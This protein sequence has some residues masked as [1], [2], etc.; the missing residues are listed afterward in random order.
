[1]DKKKQRFSAVVWWIK[2]VTAAA[3]VTV[4]AQVLTP[5]LA[6]DLKDLVL[7]QLWLIFSPCAGNLHM[8]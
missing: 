8:L 2:N 6:E 4:K 7:L 3:Q 1:M 5:A